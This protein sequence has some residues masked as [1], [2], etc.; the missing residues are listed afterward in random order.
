MADPVPSSGA[1]RAR[2]KSLGVA[3]C[4][5]SATCEEQEVALFSNDEA[6]RPEN[7]DLTVELHEVPV[8]ERAPFC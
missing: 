2:T 8:V 7:C 3:R 4:L 1:V 6:M 5:F